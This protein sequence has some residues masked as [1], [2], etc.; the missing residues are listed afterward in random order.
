MRERC[1][2]F[3]EAKIFF[4]NLRISTKEDLFFS[5]YLFV[6]YGELAKYW[7]VRLALNKLFRNN[8]AQK[9]RNLSFEYGEDSVPCRVRVFLFF[10]RLVVFQELQ[11]HEKFEPVSS[12]F[13]TITNQY[14]CHLSRKLVNYIDVC[15]SEVSIYDSIF[16][17]IAV[18]LLD[19]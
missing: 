7:E 6:F 14:S 13:R 19:P 11:N 15:R 4:Q 2:Y 5:N 18:V 3:A 12:A 10:V 9:R 17:M 16:I 1:Q 8:I